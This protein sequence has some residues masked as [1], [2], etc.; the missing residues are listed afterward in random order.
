MKSDRDRLDFELAPAK[1]VGP[2]YEWNAYHYG[3]LLQRGY[4]RTRIGA[5]FAMRRFEREWNRRGAS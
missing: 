5:A 3:V 4:T 1:E 2:N